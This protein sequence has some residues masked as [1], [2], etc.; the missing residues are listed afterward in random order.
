[1]FKINFAKNL[2]V[3]SHVNNALSM[4]CSLRGRRSKGKG[5]GIR[6]RDRARGRREEGGGEPFLSPSRAQIPPS[7]SPF[8]ACH[9]G[10]VFRK[11]RT[12]PMLT[13]KTHRNLST[14]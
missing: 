9:A 6:G 11:Q 2:S 1:M 3:L 5:K 10:Y 7:P 13:A 12:L 8:N 4:F 14:D